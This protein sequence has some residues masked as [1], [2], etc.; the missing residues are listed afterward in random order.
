M[1]IKTPAVW[2]GVAACS[3]PTPEAALLSPVLPPR[4]PQQSNSRCPCSTQRGVSKD[5]M[6]S[7][8]FTEVTWVLISGALTPVCPGVIVTPRAGRSVL[9]SLRR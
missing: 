8:E 7:T 4:L 5:L 3:L 2:R 6:K 1:G 9:R